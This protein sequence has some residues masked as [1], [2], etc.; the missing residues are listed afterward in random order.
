MKFLSQRNVWQQ[1]WLVATA[2][3][4]I[5]LGLIYPLHIVHKGNP[6][7][8]AYREVLLKELDSEKCEPYISQPIE[9]LR[10]PPTALYGVDCSAI[11]FSRKAHSQDIYPYS[12]EVYDARETARKL[13]GLIPLVIAFSCLTLAA[14]TL[15]YLLGLGAARIAQGF[16]QTA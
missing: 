14:S 11:Y 12:I 13:K 3:G 16:N 8:S 2:F 6:G 15:L 4:L 10:E 5:C 9:A 1:L 7:Q